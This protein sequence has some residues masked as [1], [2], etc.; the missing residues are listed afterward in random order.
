MATG[1]CATGTAACAWRRRRGGRDRRG[2]AAFPLRGGGANAQQHPLDTSQ[3]E[4]RAGNVEKL[5]ARIP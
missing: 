5:V 3:N 4:H 1:A 2:R